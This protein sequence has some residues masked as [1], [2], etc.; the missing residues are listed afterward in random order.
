MEVARTLAINNNIICAE[1]NTRMEDR[2]DLPVRKE[3]D[4]TPFIHQGNVRCS[5]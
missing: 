3:H 4:R 2:W 5:S 1:R